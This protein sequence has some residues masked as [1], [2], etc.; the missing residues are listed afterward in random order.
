MILVTFVLPV[1]IAGNEVKIVPVPEPVT[2]PVNVIKP[3]SVPPPVL[4]FS[5]KKC[6]LIVHHSPYA[7]IKTEVGEAL[8]TSVFNE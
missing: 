8:V 7:R 5:G 2:S 4:G 3:G 1:V 6:T